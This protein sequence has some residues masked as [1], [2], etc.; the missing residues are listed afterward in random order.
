[1]IVDRVN[2]GISY[3]S[4]IFTF[5]LRSFVN[6]STSCKIST[7]VWSESKLY[8]EAEAISRLLAIY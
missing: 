8:L 4:M 1:M 5:A 7:F 3:I 2:L 6:F